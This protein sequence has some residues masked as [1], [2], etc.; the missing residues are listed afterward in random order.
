ME[1]IN[2]LPKTQQGAESKAS[3]LPCPHRKGLRGMGLGTELQGLSVWA[4]ASCRMNCPIAWG[5]ASASGSGLPVLGEFD[6]LVRQ[7]PVTSSRPFIK[8]KAVFPSR[9]SRCADGPC[10]ADFMSQK[11]L[12]MAHNAF[13]REPTNS[14]T[15]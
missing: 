13:G 15:G 11:W 9:S 6:R 4:A 12:T 1:K 10:I 3:P 5:R 7:S 8:R 14:L 2:G